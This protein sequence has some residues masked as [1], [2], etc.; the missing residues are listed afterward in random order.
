[1]TLRAAEEQP[2]HWPKIN[3]PLFKKFSKNPF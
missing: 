3:Q 1:M 2:C